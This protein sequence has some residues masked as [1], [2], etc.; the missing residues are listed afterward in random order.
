[1]RRFS[2]NNTKKQSVKLKE[3]PAN[4]KQLI[5][6]P[7]NLDNTISQLKKEFG[8]SPDFIVREFEIGAKPGNRVA[9]VNIEGLIDKPMANDFVMRSVM[10]Y[11]LDPLQ[12]D[13]ELPDYVFQ[14]LK[15]NALAIGEIKVITDWKELLMS[16]L[17]GSTVLLLD[18]H[19]Q[20]I[21]CKTSGGESRAVSEPSTEITIRGPKEAFNERLDTNITLVRKRIKSPDLR[22]EIKEIGRVTNTSVAIMYIEGIADEK[23]VIEVRKRLEAI[24]SNSILESGY[25]EEFIQDKTFTPFPTIYN[26]ERPDVIVGNLMEGRIAILV[27]GTPF[28]LVVPTVVAQFFQSAEDYYQRSD[29]STFIRL[30]RY[31]SFVISLF[32]PS[33]YVAATTYHQEMIP[34]SLLYTLAATREGVPFPAVIEAFLMELSF[35]ILREAGIRMPRAVGQAVSIVGALILGQAAVQAGIFS[36]AMVI[37]VSI[38]GIASFATPAYNLA[39]AA[40]MIRFLLI[41]VA[42]TFGFYGLTL[43]AIIIIAHLSS[44][45]SF[46]VPFLSPF[47]PLKL[48]DQKDAL[49]RTPFGNSGSDP[50]GGLNEK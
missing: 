13:I 35:E 43:G 42:A 49:L 46:G 23:I 41:I 4:E 45:R 32:I 24:K 50:S 20:V 12:K 48:K 37:V 7:V 18:R 14:Y 5:P 36:P 19:S 8:Y 3:T 31:V 28:A 17:S 22:L 6:I 15:E 34:T 16:V 21:S 29:I 30:I 26:T 25:I 10:S 33:F 2:I 39:I 11:T 47:A 9:V 44:L 38:T 1:M 27:D 40:R